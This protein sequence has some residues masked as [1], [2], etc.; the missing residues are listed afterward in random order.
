MWRVSSVAPGRRRRR[1][2]RR[3]AIIASSRPADTADY[4]HA[5]QAIAT[6]DLAGA[7]ALLE[8]YTA[9]SPGDYRGWYT[10]GYA[11]SQ[12]G[13]KQKAIADY[14]KALQLKPDLFEA[15]LNLGLLL[16]Q[17]GD[18]AEAEQWLRKATAEDPERPR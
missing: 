11:D 7:R 3:S 9:T 8:R 5:Q 16:A 10:L 4:D 6:G 2:C 1:V 15:N 14:R 13:E 18:N 17:Q 12:T